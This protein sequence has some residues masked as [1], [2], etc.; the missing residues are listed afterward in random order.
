MGAGEFNGFYDGRRWIS[1]VLFSMFKI[2]VTLSDELQPFAEE[3]SATAHFEA[4]TPFDFL[5]N[6]VNFEITIAKEQ[7]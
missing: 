5:R 6:Y 1:H 7:M 2:S 3:F 4:H